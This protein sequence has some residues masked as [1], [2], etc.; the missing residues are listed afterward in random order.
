MGKYAVVEFTAENEVS[1]IP[2]CWLNSTATQ[3]HWPPFKEPNKVT[4]AIKN[5]INPDRIM[6]SLFDVRLFGET[7]GKY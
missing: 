5:A 2:S 1:V 6:W 4:R 7:T 3:A